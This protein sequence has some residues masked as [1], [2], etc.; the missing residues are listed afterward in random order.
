[1]PPGVGLGLA[2]AEQIINAHGGKMS[3][4]SKPG[5]GNILRLQLPVKT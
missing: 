1:M 4:E 5:T 3:H 2:I